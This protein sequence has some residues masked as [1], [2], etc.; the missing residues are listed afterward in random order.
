MAGCSNMETIE[1]DAGNIG[2]Y[3]LTNPYLH[4]FCICVAVRAGCM[5]ESRE[6]NG[7]AHLYEHMVFRNL[8]RHFGDGFY[9][10]LAKHGIDI[11]AT[12]YPD[13]ILFYVSGIKEGFA[14]ACEILTH[15]FD[16]IA[17]AARDFRAEK[18]RIKA[19]IREEEERKTLFY[20]CK[21][22]IW[23]NTPLTRR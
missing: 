23:N 7:Y 22:A 2:L 4:Q 9:T 8:K 10:L 13:S 14:F 11:N 17:I 6:E 15:L 16:D 5:Y 1:F 3:R 21:Q 12:T 19:E 18:Q 20:R